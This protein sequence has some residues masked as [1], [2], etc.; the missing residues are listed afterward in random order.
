[1]QPNFNASN[2]EVGQSFKKLR[3]KGPETAFTILE[4]HLA[5]THLLSRN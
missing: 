1:M 5:L 2:V 3:T 4:S